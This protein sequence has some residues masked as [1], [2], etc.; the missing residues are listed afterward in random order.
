LFKMI[1]NIPA[2]DIVKAIEDNLS[3]VIRTQPIELHAIYDIICRN[4]PNHFEQDN[5]VLNTFYFYWHIIFL[6]ASHQASY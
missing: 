3:S 4:I 1:G 5:I 6:W 2:D